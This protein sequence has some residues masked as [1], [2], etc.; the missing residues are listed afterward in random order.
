MNILDRK[1]KKASSGE[2]LFKPVI[3]N[4]QKPRHCQAIQRLFSKHLIREVRDDYLEQQR[5]LF[6]IL[7]PALIFQPDF[8]QQVN[9]YLQGLGK[10][11]SF[12]EQGRWVYYPWLSILAHVLEN[13]DFQ[14]VRMARNRELINTEEQKKFYEAII[15]IAGLSVGNSV[16]LA[17]VLQGG[18]RH[19]RLADH[20]HLALSNLNRIRSGVESLGLPKTV[21]TARQIYALN[22]YAQVEIFSEGLTEKNIDKFFNGPPAL[23]IVI[24]EIDNLALKFLIRQQARQRRLAVVMAADNGDNGVLDVERYDLHPATPFFHGRMGKV[25][26]EQLKKLDKMGIGRMITKHVGPE[27]ISERMQQSLLGIGKTIVS[28]PQLG[29]AAL[30]NGSA[31]AYSVRKILAGQ[32]LE[33]NR[34]LISLDE[35]LTPNY[36]SGREKQKRQRIA[37][38]FKKLF[39]LE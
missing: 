17:I 14:I 39:N 8:S 10:R 18:G 16:A 5:E 33:D 31:V 2:G 26:Y 29:G 38:K 3:F 20:D 22:P 37:Q 1:L 28:W 36:F 34:A 32:S 19:I 30:L 6:A 15:G 25:S 24:D 27:N 11:T 12:G 4:L 9:N 21:I 23:E 13:K 35:K 7:H